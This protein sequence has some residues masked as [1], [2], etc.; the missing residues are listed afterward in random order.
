MTEVVTEG[1]ITEERGFGVHDAT[2]M[3]QHVT[4]AGGEAD[5]F[6][7]A[8]MALARHIRTYLVTRFP[9]G[10]EWCVNADLANGIIKFSIPVLMGVSHWYVVNLRRFKS[11]GGPGTDL[12]RAV[13][14]GAGEI[15]ERYRLSRSVFDQAAFL[16]AREQHSKL[17]VSGR[18]IP[19]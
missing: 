17:V 19:T 5:P 12:D 8:D 9:M 4:P 13:L 14:H 6:K 11:A 18:A 7:D 16:T 2:V 10:Y 1:F 15:L 3:V